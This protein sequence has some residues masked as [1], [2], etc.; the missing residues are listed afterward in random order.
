MSSSSLIRMQVAG[1]S[2]LL[3]L[4]T[5]LHLAKSQETSVNTDPARTSNIMKIPNLDI[6]VCTQL[7]GALFNVGL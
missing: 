5:R 2:E 7:I 1:S 3:Q 6:C 4:S